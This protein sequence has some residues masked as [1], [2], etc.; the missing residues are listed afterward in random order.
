MK[1]LLICS[2]LTFMAVLVFSFFLLTI[3]LFKQRE[4]LLGL[5][6]LLY[7]IP[8]FLCLVIVLGPVVRICRL[9]RTNTEAAKSRVRSWKEAVEQGAPTDEQYAE[10]KGAALRGIFAVLS[11]LYGFF[12]LPTLLLKL[13]LGMRLGARVAWWP[14]F[15]PVM[16]VL[17]VIL[18]YFVAGAHHPGVALGVSI[19][20]LLLKIFEVVSKFETDHGAL[21]MLSLAKHQVG[22]SAIIFAAIMIAASF[23]CI[24]RCISLMNPSS[25]SQP[26]TAI[27]SLYFSVT[28][29]ATVGY[30]DISPHSPVA[31]LACVG[32]IVSGCLVL[33]FGVNLAMTVWLQ[34]FTDTKATFPAAASAAKEP[35]S[36]AAP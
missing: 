34:K 25:Y 36:G 33:V 31:K 18:S 1:R 28:T 8:F 15:E 9:A 30:G 20:L 26:L 27:D 10:A 13:A 17:F 23:G 5:L 21:R 22:L 12:T 24:H 32:E 29:F 6:P 19:Y 2:A 35:K 16:F 7:A 14:D 11:A 4:F 3:V